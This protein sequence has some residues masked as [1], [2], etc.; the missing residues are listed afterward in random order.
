LIDLYYPTVIYLF[1][2]C[3]S[4]ILSCHPQNKGK[5]ETPAAAENLADIEK[6]KNKT[7]K[8]LDEFM[9]ANEKVKVDIQAAK[10]YH[11]EII[12]N[13]LIT[14]LVTQEQLFLTA[15]KQLEAVISTLPEERV[16]MVKDRFHTFFQSGASLAP[17]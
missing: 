4:S 12:D 3:I 16:N 17:M 11:D 1:L 6:F 9:Y 15:A 14:L 8:G 7:Q 2:F 13:V 5:G 10:A